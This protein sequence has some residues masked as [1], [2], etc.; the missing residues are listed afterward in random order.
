MQVKRRKAGAAILAP[1]FAA[2]GDE[3]RL[4]L[5]TRVCKEGPVS[6]TELA[7][8]S[9]ISRQATTKHLEVLARAGLV[10]GIRQGRERLYEFDPKR[11]EQAREYLNVVALQ[12]DQA[13]GRL[14]LLVETEHGSG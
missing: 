9:D 12:W 2:L 6:I 5:V 10:R 11:L 14:K 8:G 13:L 3:R 1:L 7:S 4:G